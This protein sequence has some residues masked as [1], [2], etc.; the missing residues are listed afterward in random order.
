MTMTAFILAK[1]SPDSSGMD[2]LNEI[3]DD[4]FVEEAYLIYG[5][6]DMIVKIE[7]KN[8]EDL[9]DF[10]FNRLRAVRGVLDTATC[11]CASC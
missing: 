11:I 5:A 1:L 9:D 10:I 3:R 6:F 2:L 8:P 7:V 4:D